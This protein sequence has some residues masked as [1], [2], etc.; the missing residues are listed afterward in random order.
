MPLKARFCPKCG[1]NLSFKEYIKLSYIHSDLEGYRSVKC[2]NCKRVLIDGRSNYFYQGFLTFVLIGIC[3]GIAI[4]FHLR[5][6][7]IYMPFLAIFIGVLSSFI[8]Y[9]SIG[10]EK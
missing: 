1:K 6:K 10:F 7:D 8:A 4:L 2:Q 9:I 5:I 3:F